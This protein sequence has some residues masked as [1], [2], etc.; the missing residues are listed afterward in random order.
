MFFAR[1]V[2]DG[3]E[4]CDDEHYN[5]RGERHIAGCVGQASCQVQGNAQQRSADAV[6]RVRRCGENEAVPFSLATGE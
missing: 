4:A 6:V 3:M 1:E 5:S 2:E